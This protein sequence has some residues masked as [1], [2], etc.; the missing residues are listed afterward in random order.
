MIPVS[1]TKIIISNLFKKR[2]QLEAELED[3]LKRPA[4]YS[5]QGSYSETCRSVD[6]IRQELTAIDTEIRAMAC[7]QGDISFIYP[8]KV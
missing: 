5:I 8:K 7:G 2:C 4:S 1:A 6:D 3:A